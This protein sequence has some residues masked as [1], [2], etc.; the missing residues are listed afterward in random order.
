MHEALF[1]ET[2]E[3]LAGIE[4]PAC[5]AGEREA[6]EWLAA[7]LSTLGCDA[8]V[9]EEAAYP[10][11]AMPIAELCALGVLGGI[12]TLRGRPV[13]GGLLAAV[14]G[15]LIA[16]DVSNG[17]RLFRRLTMRRRPT[18]NV[19]A[20]SGDRSAER[21]LV[22]LA[23]H[24]AAPTGFI[25]DQSAQ[26]R[27]WERFPGV[28]DR[29]NTSIPLWWFVF[30]PPLAVAVG[31]ALGRRRLVGAATGV[32]ALSVGT[33]MNIA[34]SPVVPGANDNLTGV[35]GLVGLARALEERPIEGLRVILA[36]C[37]AEETL[38]GGIHGFAARHFPSLPIERTWFVN[39]D[40]VGSPHL[41]LLEGEGPVVMEDYE[42]GFKDLIAEVAAGAG[43][44]LRRGM[45]SRNST[46]SVIPNRA[47]YPVGMLVSITDWKALANYHWPSDVP[48][49]VE[50]ETVEHAVR[51]TEAVARRLAADAAA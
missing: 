44:P 37:G 42:A 38:Q 17:P 50:Y 10:D 51:L 16:D 6:A 43:V 5:S 14:A 23:H 49:N 11:F 24:D 26:R 41:V 13:S 29:I 33:M 39:L 36:S 4:R 30:G 34:R 48:E 35:A 32:G 12:A 8:R 18:W 21:T 46:D 40:T 31:G 45:R 1:R 47:G 19:V 20:T 25:F 28:I 7:H 27:I 3:Y 2:I 22:V 15:L 9:E